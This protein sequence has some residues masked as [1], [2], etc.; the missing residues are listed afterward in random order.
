MK[1]TIICLSLIFSLVLSSCDVDQTKKGKMPEV[2][3]DMKSGKLP[4]YE[5]NWADVNVGTKTKTITV[6]KLVV[7]MEEVEVDVPY[8]DVDVPSDAGEKIEKSIVVEAEVKDY[9]HDIKIKE[10]YATDNYL[11][12]LSNLTNTNKKL[13]GEKTIRVSD[14]LI[15]NAPDLDVKHYIIGTRPPSDHNNQYTYIKSKSALAKKM[16]NG[17][18]IFNQ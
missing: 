5:V 11:Y 2:D 18:L 7:V 1:N 16:T 15:I 9:M 4:A 17:K 10:V 14:R 12:V 3:V 13:A 8:V 6:P